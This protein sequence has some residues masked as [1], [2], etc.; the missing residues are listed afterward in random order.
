MLIN[1]KKNMFR[2]SSNK[3]VGINPLNS[4]VVSALDGYAYLCTTLGTIEGRIKD[5]Y[6]YPLYS[7][8]K[9]ILHP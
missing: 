5:H 2:Y 8:A 3:G 7:G 6:I 1:R 4:L 9:L